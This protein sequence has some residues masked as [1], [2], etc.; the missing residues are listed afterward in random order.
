MGTTQHSGEFMECPAYRAV[1][2]MHTSK[3]MVVAIR[4]RITSAGCQKAHWIVHKAECKKKQAEHVRD[5][6]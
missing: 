2:T 1:L 3:V 5:G 6:K 4:R